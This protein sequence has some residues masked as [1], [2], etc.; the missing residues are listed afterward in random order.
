MFEEI[1]KSIKAHLY[2]RT[3]SPL[4]GAF[5]FSWLI[6]NFKFIMLI[7]S[8]E[9]IDVKYDILESQ[10]Y[11]DHLHYL[12]YWLI[13]PFITSVIFLYVYPFPAK[14]VFKFTRKRQQQLKELRQSIDDEEL[15]DNKE[16]RKLKREVYELEQSFDAVV[17]KKDEE[18][19]ILYSDLKDADE[20]KT[21]YLQNIQKLEEK[22]TLKIDGLTTEDTT[23]NERKHKEIEIKILRLIAANRG[24]IYEHDLITK[25]GVEELKYTYH[26]DELIK[27]SQINKVESGNGSYFIILLQK[28][29]ERLI[30]ENL[31]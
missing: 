1:T 2:D 21:K 30:D 27:L 29:K 4:L 14:W 6:W 23:Y 9:S 25:L 12:Y 17:K 20:M 7:F 24:K 11:T 16:S 10:L 13:T 26:R 18:L 19:K 3:S 22:L 31:L 8:S 28:G 15:L 5:L